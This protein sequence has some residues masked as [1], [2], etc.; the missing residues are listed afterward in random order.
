MRTRRRRLHGSIGR[1]VTAIRSGITNGS[2]E[3]ARGIIARRNEVRAPQST[4]KFAPN[5]FVTLSGVETLVNQNNQCFD[6]I[7]LGL[8]SRNAVVDEA[9]MRAKH[10][11]RIA[12]N[13]A[14]QRVH[15]RARVF[16]RMCN[17]HAHPQI[18]IA[19]KTRAGLSVP[20]RVVIAAVSGCRYE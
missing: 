19:R 5:L 17:T 13:D 2:D 8:Q 3:I 11:R 9:T 12:R 20:H 18:Q 7:G 10:S 16:V 14:A 4:E 15:M 6:P 1:V